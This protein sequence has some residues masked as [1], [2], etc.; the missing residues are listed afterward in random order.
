VYDFSAEP[1]PF[2]GVGAPIEIG[3]PTYAPAAGSSSFSLADHLS[4]KSTLYAIGI[5]VVGL[6]AYSYWVRSVNK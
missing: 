1:T 2:V 3:G 4:S 6:A 5:G